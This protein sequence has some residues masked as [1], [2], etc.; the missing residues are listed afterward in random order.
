[1]NRQLNYNWLTI[2]ETKIIVSNYLNMKLFSR[3][4][5]DNWLKKLVMPKSLFEMGYGKILYIK[6][7]LSIDW[8]K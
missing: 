5:I 2:D 6:N 3:H 4:L 8:K 1:M 7:W